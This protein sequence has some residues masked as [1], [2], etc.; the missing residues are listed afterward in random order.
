MV[1]IDNLAPPLPMQDGS[2]E[3]QMLCSKLGI[4]EVNTVN[5]VFWRD[6]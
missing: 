3:Y 5:V 2:Y 4:I 6:L 1:P